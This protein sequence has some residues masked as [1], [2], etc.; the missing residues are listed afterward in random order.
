MSAARVVQ[1]VGGPVAP[2]ALG[3]TAMHEHVL[4]S[5]GDGL[6]RL[7]L[8]AR[9]AGPFESDVWHE[10]LSL[11][12]RSRLQYE[13]SALR[14]NL[15]L[16]DDELMLAELR[17]FA[18]A[19]GRALVDV[20]GIGIRGDAERV[21]ALAAASGVRIVMST[22]W[23]VSHFWPAEQLSWSVEQH[24]E[25]MVRELREGIDGTTVRAGH[26]KCGVDRLDE[27]ERR[28]LVAAAAASQATGAAVTVHPGFGVGSDGR[29]IVR[30][31][32]A[33]GLD[34]ERLVIAH[35]DAFLSEPDVRRLLH[36]ASAWRLQLDY[37][38]ELLA[39]GVTLS[40]DCFGHA[41]SRPEAGVMEESDW[42]RLAGIVSLVREGDGDRL[43]LGTDTF[44]PML[45]RRGGGHGYR[46]LCA[47]VLPRLRE[48]GV[49]DWDLEQMT[50]VTPQR[51]LAIP[52]FD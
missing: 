23:Y 8:R 7:H 11:A 28:V 48:A 5:N 33:A 49:S 43:V 32:R 2:E 36:D 3:L 35:A 29:R 1:T 42:K 16:D 19:G 31:L 22:G 46:H 41:W 25:L 27:P 9:P 13:P 15:T 10:P 37:H 44:L 21:A 30:L 51:L 45:T 14:A 12:Q 34:P 6:R 50:V 20:G 4:L 40:F 47:F 17:D 24:A 18:A 26:I 39:Q 38:R 52:F